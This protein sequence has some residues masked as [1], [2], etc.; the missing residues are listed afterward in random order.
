MAGSGGPG[1]YGFCVGEDEQPGAVG[2]LYFG[3]SADGVPVAETE[4]APG[5]NSGALRVAAREGGAR[6]LWVH[7]GDLAAHG[8]CARPGFTRL[9]AAGPQRAGPLPEVSDAAAAFAALQRCFVGQWGHHRAEPGHL[10]EDGVTLQL[11]QDG[12]IVGLCR[13]TPERV[14]DDIGLIPEVREPA[15]YQQML[16]GACGYLGSGPV[17]IC[18]W[19]QD[20]STI[21]AWQSLGFSVTEATPGWEADLSTGPAA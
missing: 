21:A 17:E 13:V 4:W 15:R 1:P 9:T 2:E 11:T 14:I 8:F 16:A 3:V 18:S 7:G 10:S 6:L 5:A 20:P 19:G 12:A